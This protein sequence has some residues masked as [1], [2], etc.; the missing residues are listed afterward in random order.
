MGAAS[1]SG[2]LMSPENF[3][4]DFSEILEIDVNDVSMDTQLS[5][6]SIWDSINVLGYMML[7]DEKMGRQVDPENVKNAQT[8]RDL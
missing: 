5:G 4:Q 1:L 6:L 7:V 8:I 2:S 3:L